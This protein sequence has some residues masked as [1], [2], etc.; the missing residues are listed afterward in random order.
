[1]EKIAIQAG[2]WKKHWTKSKDTYNKKTA[3]NSGLA[4]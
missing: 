1:M 3:H 4:Q 2:F